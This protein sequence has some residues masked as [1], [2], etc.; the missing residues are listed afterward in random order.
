[1]IQACD[2]GSPLAEFASGNALR[3]EIRKT[4]RAVLEE[5]QA[6]RAAPA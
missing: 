3:K 2:H 6:S 1:M 5:V 4:A